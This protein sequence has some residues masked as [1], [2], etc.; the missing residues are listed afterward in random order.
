MKQKH[1]FNEVRMESTG[2]A[3]LTGDL[4]W[5]HERVHG[6]RQWGIPHIRHVRVLERNVLV[7]EITTLGDMH[8]VLTRLF[9]IPWGP[10]A[11]LPS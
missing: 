7:P 2:A 8:H 9:R 1:K 4:L 10:P 3:L 6:L 11:S 5:T